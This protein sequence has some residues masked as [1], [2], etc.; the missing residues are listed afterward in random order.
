MIFLV[1]YLFNF[2]VSRHKRSFSEKYLNNDEEEEE[3]N[4]YN[5]FKTL[6]PPNDFLKKLAKDAKKT[7]NISNFSSFDKN[8]SDS[9][10]PF[11]VFH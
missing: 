1:K 5:P 3:E 8:S 11:L 10:N 9:L 6:N 4:V 2:K 7:P